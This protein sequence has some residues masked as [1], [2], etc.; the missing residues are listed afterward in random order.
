M[1]T[2]TLNAGT[3]EL[4]QFVL[5][6]G[7]KFFGILLDALDPEEGPGD[8]IRYIKPANLS[9]WIESSDEGLVEMIET[10][11]VDGIDLYLK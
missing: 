2:M 7:E 6:N 3:G 5:K 9:T 8:E 10:D 4:A 11:H 1:M